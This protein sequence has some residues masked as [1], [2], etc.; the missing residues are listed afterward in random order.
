VAASK[1]PLSRSASHFLFVGI[2]GYVVALKRDD[3]EI[4]WSA[5]LPKGASLVPLVVED[6]FVFAV[7]GGEVSCLDAR[8]GK[9]VWHNKLKGYGTSYAMLAGA[10]NPSAMAALEAAAAAAAAA[11]ASAAAAAS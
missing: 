3:G 10:Q 2:K 5:R 1:V 6:G 8:T 9:L 7:S 4:A 11:G